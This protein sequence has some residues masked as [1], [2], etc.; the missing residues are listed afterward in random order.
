MAFRQINLINTEEI[1][2]LKKIYDSQILFLIALKD[3]S[4]KKF[5]IGQPRAI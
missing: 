4:K 2:Y 5:H 1:S 3:F